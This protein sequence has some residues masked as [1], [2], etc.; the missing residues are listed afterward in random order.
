MA[1]SRHASQR[2][3]STHNGNCRPPRGSRKRGRNRVAISLALQGN[4]GRLCSRAGATRH[5]TLDSRALSMASASQTDP[6]RRSFAQRFGVRRIEP[7]TLFWSAGSA[8]LPLRRAPICA[9]FSGAAL[10]LLDAIKG[11]QSSAAEPSLDVYASLVAGGGSMRKAARG[12]LVTIGSRSFHL[13]VRT[14]GR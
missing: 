14:P 9:P 11:G 7:G 5:P 12:H 6:N 4:C 10:S 8:R 3:A 2:R 1:D 13:S